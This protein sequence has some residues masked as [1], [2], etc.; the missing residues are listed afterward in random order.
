ADSAGGRSN[1]VSPAAVFSAGARLRRRAVQSAAHGRLGRERARRDLGPAPHH[2]C[3]GAA[4]PP[5]RRNLGYAPV[6]PHSD[7]RQARRYAG[8]LLPRFGAVLRLQTV[9]YGFLVVSLAPVRGPTPADGFGRG[10][11]LLSF[12]D[13]MDL[14]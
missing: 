13:N 2:G 4:D 3:P 14:P 6:R 8:L 5:C 7:V 12:G 10:L 11:V 9:G 1:P